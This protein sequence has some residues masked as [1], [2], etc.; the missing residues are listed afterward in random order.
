MPK[1]PQDQQKEQTQVR[2]DARQKKRVHKYMEKFKQQTHA[3]IS[4]S[5]AVRT[6]VDQSLDREGV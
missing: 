4:F 3:A 1:T 6:L 2:M 5:E